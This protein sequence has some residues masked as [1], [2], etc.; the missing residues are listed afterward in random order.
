MQFT[1]IFCCILLFYFAG[2][3][4]LAPHSLPK[5]ILSHIFSCSIFEINNLSFFGELENDEMLSGEDYCFVLQLQVL[6]DLVRRIYRKTRCQGVIVIVKQPLKITNFTQSYISHN[7]CFQQRLQPL[8]FY[9]LI[10]LKNAFHLLFQ[11]LIKNN[12]LQITVTIIRNFDLE[13]YF[14]IPPNSM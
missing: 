11:I 8:L 13:G 4:V 14:F 6:V 5:P 9:K 3:A 12:Q 7:G 2:Q 1:I 10:V